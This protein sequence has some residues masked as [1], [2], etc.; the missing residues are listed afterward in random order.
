[1]NKLFNKG[2]WYF[3]YRNVMTIYI[4]LRNFKLSRFMKYIKTCYVNKFIKQ[5][6]KLSVYV[7]QKPGKLKS[8]EMDWW[9]WC[10]QLHT[11]LLISSL[12]RT[13]AVTARIVTITPLLKSEPKT[14]LITDI[15]NVNPF[16]LNWIS[17]KYILI[18]FSQL[19]SWNSCN[20]KLYVNPLE[21]HKLWVN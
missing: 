19:F 7:V 6:F 20:F 16:L 17:C 9:R 10:W 21:T 5:Q 2:I 11:G 13:V 3:R 4:L 12:T 18:N 14:Y 1:M 8:L 15:E